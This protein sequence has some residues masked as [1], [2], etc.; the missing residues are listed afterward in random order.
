MTSLGDRALWINVVASVGLFGMIATGLSVLWRSWVARRRGGRNEIFW[1]SGGGL[2]TAHRAVALIASAW[3]L[4]V[5]FSG[6]WLAY[7]SLVRA[8]NIAADPTYYHGISAPPGTARELTGTEIAPMSQAASRA[9]HAA[10]PGLPVTALRLRYFGSMPQAVFVTGGA[11][12]RQLVFDTRY[13]RQVSL[14]EPEYP[15]TAYPFGWQVHQTVK[16]I[17][18]GSFLGI[19]GRVADALAGLSILYLALSG[20]VMYFGMWVRRRRAGRAALLWR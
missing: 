6:A 20:S 2:R 19:P 11:E 1:R 3:L 9:R 17:H 13:G 16:R 8:L 10:I 7:E 5:A 4:I 14:T 12:A 15:R 18:N